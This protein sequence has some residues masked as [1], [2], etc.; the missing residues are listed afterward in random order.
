MIKVNGKIHEVET[1]AVVCIFNRAEHGIRTEDEE[2]E[3][4]W[5]YNFATDGFAEVLYRSND[6][7]FPIK[8]EPPREQ[9]RAPHAQRDKR[10]SLDQRQDERK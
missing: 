4:R 8:S 7:E 10:S 6:E 5:L 9:S 3:L 2:E 1:G